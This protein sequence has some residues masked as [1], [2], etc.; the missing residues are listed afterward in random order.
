V[1][2]RVELSAVSPAD[3]ASDPAVRSFIDFLAA[4]IVP[5][6]TGDSGGVDR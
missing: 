1:A 5:A 3:R 2:D 6:L 4:N